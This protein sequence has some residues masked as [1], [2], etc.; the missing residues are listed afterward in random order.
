V[1]AR[2]ALDRAEHELS[3][4]PFSLVLADR[5]GWIV[6]RRVGEKSL[7]ASLD[8]VGVVQGRQ[9]L[10]ETTG[11]NS[12]ATP[13]ELRRGI[14]VHGGEHFL[15]DLKI[16]SCYG[17]PILHPVSRR[18][19]GVLDVTCPNAMDS[20]LLV[21]FL[22]RT[23]AEIEARIV[24]GSRLTEQ[25][26]LEMYQARQHRSRPV[27][28]IG[29]D[30]ALANTAA[31]DLLDAS[32]H[33]LLRALAA[34]VVPHRTQVEGVV[35]NSG[36]NV[37]VEFE[38][39]PGAGVMVRIDPGEPRSARIGRRRGREGALREPWRADL[40]EFR[41]RRVPVLISGEPGTGRTAAANDLAGGQPP[42]F[43]KITYPNRTHLDL[44]QLTASGCGHLVVIEG[45]HVLPATVLD[46]IARAVDAGEL[47]LAVTSCRVADLDGAA[48]DLASRFA[49]RVELPPLRMRRSELPALIQAMLPKLGITGL[50]ILPKTL[51]LL[52]AAPWPGN[53]GELAA[54]LKH[55]HAA[56]DVDAVTPA[57]LPDRYR[58][59][60]RARGLPPIRQAERD[61]IVVAL[62][63]CGGN[64]THAAE[65]LGIG[66]ATLHR[67]V[68]ILGIQY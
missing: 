25:R 38:Q 3:G 53:L 57:D 27:L 29:D 5:D 54:L 50:R 7:H 59:G 1:A 52:A 31:N 42:I 62:R 58:A 56:G 8:R 28:V 13:F 10:E 43:L 33:A 34:E 39:V 14:A 18:L 30:L 65:R 2:S 46:A 51:E 20:P 32:D 19:E 48:A 17:L 40:V 6:D 11:T 9:F 47:W 23:V 67:R 61:A 22:R 41:R 16:F 60:H 35:L 37:F 45:I 15:D 21:P 63:A 12:I 49:A 64:K 24:E 26:M 4:S 44:A 36:R 68:R 55:L 66:R